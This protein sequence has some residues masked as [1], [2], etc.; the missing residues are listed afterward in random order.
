MTPTALY[1]TA[2]VLV[3]SIVPYTIVLMRGINGKLMEKAEA[4][5]GQG[6]GEGE[7]TWELLRQW[8]VLNWGR[9]VIVLTGYVMGVMGS[10]LR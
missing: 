8:K 3:P 1:A 6:K 7:E 2:M 4:G 9:A 10:V 5:Q